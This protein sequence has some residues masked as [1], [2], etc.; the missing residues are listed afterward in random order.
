MNIS[1]TQL[2]IKID[3]ANAALHHSWDRLSRVLKKKKKKRNSSQMSASFKNKQESA[4]PITLKTQLLLHYINY[5][6]QNG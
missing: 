5:L 1:R 3:E 6:S 4:F 2:T